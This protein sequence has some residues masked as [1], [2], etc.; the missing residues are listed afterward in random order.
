[1][2]CFVKEEV[3]FLNKPFLSVIHQNLIIYYN[4]KQNIFIPVM[5]LE[6][7]VSFTKNMYK[8]CSIETDWFKGCKTF[9]FDRLF[10][11]KCTVTFRYEAP[12]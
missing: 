8:D 3:N 10:K 11:K 4:N 2:F 6:K 7:S 1:M 9:F 5:I 12:L